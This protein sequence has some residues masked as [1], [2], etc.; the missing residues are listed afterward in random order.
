MQS[1]KTEMI[2][3]ATKLLE[4]RR[5]IIDAINNKEET[6]KVQEEN[7]RKID[8]QL[9][10]ELINFC[11]YLQD[12]EAKKKRAENRMR[13]EQKIRIQK[14]QDQKD[15][16]KQHED[17]VIS[18]K[19]LDKK[20]TSL[21]KYE[22]YL[23]SISK[24]YPDQYHDLQAIIDR[25][26]TLMGSNEKL[27]KEHQLI[28]SQLEKLKYESSQYEAQK[29]QEI[30]QYNNEIKDFQKK[31]EEKTNE[32]NQLQQTAESYSNQAQ[33][34]NLILGRIFMAI[35]NLN[36]RCQE[37]LQ[38][39]KQDFDESKQEKQNKEEKKTKQNQEKKKLNKDKKDEG[40]LN[41]D[42]DYEQKS[43]LALSKLKSIGLYMKDFKFIIEGC[44]AERAYK[45][46]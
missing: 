16:E 36:T 29:N 2:S 1:K 3:P 17:L 10:E 45:N 23:E 46:K 39:M 34:K 4:K 31:L 5:K 18:S 42:E 35:D 33:S 15:L 7:I 44:K 40:T 19:K 22:E 21:K 13:E 43:Q 24:N 30:L 12:N 6:F 37:G 8:M 20:V 26:N 32:K 28:D 41:D 9:Q 38:R 11:K 14:E 25:Y 27:V